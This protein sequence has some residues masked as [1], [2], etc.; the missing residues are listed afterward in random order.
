MSKSSSVAVNANV[1]K[2]IG[3]L[4][5]YPIKGS[6][7][8]KT[9][10][11]YINALVEAGYEVDVYF[12][13][14]ITVK[15]S[16]LRRVV[17]EYLREDTNANLIAGWHIS[18]NYEALIATW[19]RTAEIVAAYPHAERKLYFVQDF[20]AYFNPMN[21]EYV[22]AE[23]SYK[24]GLTAV[25]MGNWLAKFLAETYKSPVYPI[26]LGANSKYYKNTNSYRENS[27]CFIY[28]PEKPRRCTDLLHGAVEQII[29]NRPDIKIYSY[30]STTPFPNP[31]VVNLGIIKDADLADLY[32]RCKVGICFSLSNPSRI[33]FEMMACG[34]PVVELHRENNLYDL[35]DTGS[36]LVSE[37]PTAV[38][39]GVLKI[40]NDPQEQKRLATGGTEFMLQMDINISTAKFLEFIKKPELIS[41]VKPAEIKRLYNKENIKGSVTDEDYI[42]HLIELYQELPADLEEEK[43]ERRL[44]RRYKVLLKLL[45]L[46]PYS[47]RFLK[48]TSIR[49]LD[50]FANRY[51]SF[52][53]RLEIYR[54]SLSSGMQVFFSK[55]RSYDLVSFD[56]FDT[57]VRRTCSPEDVKIFTAYNTQLLFGSNILGLS[58]ED[59]YELRRK[60][61][62]EIAEA[63]ME[64]GECGEYEISEVLEKVLSRLYVGKKTAELK[65]KINKLVGLE[66]EFERRHLYV[67][68]AGLRY[69]KRLK[70]KHK[71][72]LSDFYM[73]SNDLRDI[74]P[75]EIL[76]EVSAIYVS[77]E[78]G[79]NKISGKAF[80]FIRRKYPYSDGRSLHVGDSRWSDVDAANQ[81]GSRG[82]HWYNLREE[83]KRKQLKERFEKRIAKTEPGK[84]PEFAFKDLVANLEKKTTAPS[85]YSS[86]QKRL[87]RAGVKFAPITFF[88]ILNLMETAIKG[89][90]DKIYFCTREGKFF[91]ELYELMRSRYSFNIEIPGSEL[92]EVSRMATFF[93]TLGTFDT[94]N[95]MRLWN[96]YS[97]QSPIALFKSLDL[98]IAGYQ[99]FLKKHAVDPNKEAYLWEEPEFKA[100]LADRDFQKKITTA[101]QSRRSLLQAYLEQKGLD[102]SSKNAFV[103]DIGWKGSIQDNLAY[104]LKN[105]NLLGVYFGF[106]KPHNPQLANSQKAGYAYD[107]RYDDEN[108][109]NLIGDNLA[110]I[111]MMFNVTGGSVLGYKREGETVVSRRD[112]DAGED[113]I[114]HKYI[115]YFQRGIV[116]SFGPLLDLTLNY[117]IS[118]LEAKTYVRDELWKFLNNPGL[119]VADAF[120]ELKHNE[121]F[122]TGQYDDRRRDRVN[123]GLI[124]TIKYFTN[125]EF[126][127]RVV[128]DARESR[129]R[130]AYLQKHDH[131]GLVRFWVNFLKPKYNDI[132]SKINKV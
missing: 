110:P 14:P 100:L 53:D 120:L 21:L 85:T 116:S 103:V 2:R 131:T 101:L 113:G 86:Q 82:L 60:V 75:Q 42:V 27:I 84:L 5:P 73:L 16:H 10:F 45:R 9:M 64:Q 123:L 62:A 17:K 78:T 94:Q 119:V 107:F 114:H 49:W 127:A 74:V 30:G 128:E 35:P 102:D 1:P 48:Q 68:T 95:L 129:W 98:D 20:E 15:E 58:V 83:L 46:M 111:E 39:T 50:S 125:R 105:T 6:G 80:E 69:F 33:P 124:N 91:Q 81:N 34:L 38:A 126:K 115:S 26:F 11:V 29:A 121:T 96:Q 28:Q 106:M 52:S 37:N 18:G 57:L 7:G 109:K 24:L 122:G 56:L 4:V 25:T 89:G 70:A 67:D 41:G 77:C 32:N 12:N 79:V 55:F 23:N 132:R 88:F 8:H 72:I 43:E 65:E 3:W 112:V 61:E 40:L 71:L 93:P 92:I 44:R 108:T 22:L 54:F 87:Y 99:D 13:T 66:K 36:L 19:Y 130:G 118:S 51:K 117:S 59:I 63:K 97:W 47:I 31:N 90:Y 104:L 76:R